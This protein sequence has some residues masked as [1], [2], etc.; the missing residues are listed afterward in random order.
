L[1]D[2]SI[3]ETPYDLA[4]IIGFTVCLIGFFG[5]LI[6]HYISDK[7]EKP[8]C[9]QTNISF[10]VF[11]NLI[12]AGILIIFNIYMAAFVT[13][14]SY[15]FLYKLYEAELGQRYKANKEGMLNNLLSKDEH[16]HPIKIMKYDIPPIEKIKLNYF[17]VPFLVSVEWTVVCVVKYLVFKY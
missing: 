5:E 8:S 14:L 4:M 12:V 10:F 9:L 6:F 16:R 1:L 2:D 13:L 11:F 3:I 17:P 7:K 15:F